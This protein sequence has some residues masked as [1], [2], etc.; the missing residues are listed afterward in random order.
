MNHYIG[1]DLGTS[2]L[3]GLLTDREGRILRSASR[4]YPVEYPADGWTQQDP[5]LWE[6]AMEE[7]IAELSEGLREDIRGIS[8][9]G[10]M[11]G[12]VILDDAGRPIRPCILWNDGRTASQTSYLNEDIGRKELSRLTGNIAF[13]GFTAPKILWLRENE[14]DNFSRIASLML[15]KDYL[16]YLLSGELS[17]DYSDA[18]GTLLLDV[19][20]KRWSSRMCGICGVDEKW[21][22]P[23]H[24][25][26]E[27]VGKLKECYG[28]PNA[29]VTAGAGDNAA[30]AVGTGTVENGSCNIS[31]GTSGTVFISSDSF[32]S[33]GNN[34]LHS[35]CHADGRWHLMGCILSAA[36][37]RKWWLEDILGGFDYDLDEEEIL[38]CDSGDTL[39]LPYLAGERCPHND[40]DI[41]GAFINL[42]STTTREQMSRSV[43][44]GVAF[45][46]R[47]CM[48]TAKLSC[49]AFIETTLCGGGA[50]S[51]AWR[52]IL[53]DVLDTP[54]DIPETEQGP[55]YGA[56]ILAMVG[57]GEYPSVDEACEKLIRTRERIYPDHDAVKR[58]DEKYTVF[59]KLYPL[60][61]SL[62]D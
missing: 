32:V 21:L 23:L 60:L 24:E 35:F 10:Q 14:P 39:F 18:S 26:W 45:A 19:E 51:R 28:L 61:K 43:M 13:A 57:S 50:K 33:D 5:D 15:P 6:K 2:S 11:H 38:R 31:L 17:C 42:S 47:D 37:C 25:S 1:I 49:S 7:V 58:Y 12:L 29:V 40:V 8:L 56:A 16:V 27:V 36:S 46:L 62:D 53:S 22:P 54:I 55:A 4:D 30:A 34:S 59:K 44:E 9:G 3:K 48:E 20:N 41:R 52:Q